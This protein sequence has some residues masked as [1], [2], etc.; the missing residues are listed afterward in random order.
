MTLTEQTNEK[1]EISANLTIFY[2]EITTIFN[3][4]VPLSFQTNRTGYHPGADIS[5][6]P[7]NVQNI[8][9]V[10]WTPDVISNYRASL[11]TS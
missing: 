6:L 4:G 11:I 3:D 5:K 10:V 7:Q 2:D 9:N 1:I 8:C